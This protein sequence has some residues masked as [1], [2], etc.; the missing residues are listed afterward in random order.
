M[1]NNLSKNERVEIRKG[2]Y[3]INLIYAFCCSLVVNIN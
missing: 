3:E 2:I 1:I